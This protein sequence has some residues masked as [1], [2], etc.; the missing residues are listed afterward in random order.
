MN[1]SSAS[2]RR[3]PFSMHVK[4]V[5]GMDF[6]VILERFWIAVSVELHAPREGHHGRVEIV[7]VPQEIPLLSPD[8]LSPP[9]SYI[10]YSTHCG[11]FSL[12]PAETNETVDGMQIQLDLMHDYSMHAQ[13][14]TASDK[15]SGGSN[16]AMKHVGGPQPVRPSPVQCC[17]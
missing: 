4:A 7:R 12:N 16:L 9:K 11:S 6:G 10:P 1:E 8:V 5:T 17:Q 15:I 3:S 14:S 2:A 13:S